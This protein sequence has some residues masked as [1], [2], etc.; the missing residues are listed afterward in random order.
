MHP[1]QVSFMLGLKVYATD[2]AANEIH[3]ISRLWRKIVVLTQSKYKKRQQNKMF[4]Y[5]KS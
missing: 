4:P 2:K 5:E 1:D 3:H